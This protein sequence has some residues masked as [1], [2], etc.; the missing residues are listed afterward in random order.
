M[1]TQVPYGPI[2]R[3][4]WLKA[5]NEICGRNTADGF[6]SHFSIIDRCVKAALPEERLL[7]H[8]KFIH[9]MLTRDKSPTQAGYYRDQ[10]DTYHV[11]PKCPH[12]TDVADMV[13]GWM[14]YSKELLRHSSFKTE[15]E[16]YKRI[17]MLHYDF[18]TI[19]P[20]PNDNDRVGRLLILNQCVYADV[21]PIIISAKSYP[22][23]VNE[24]GMATSHYYKKMN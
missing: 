20:F 19:C 8:P 22:N 6:H 2:W 4:A 7:L 14:A 15:S 3:Q 17:L 18:C 23:Y 16:A 9:D 11:P 10:S 12:W 24:I 1:T 5:N 21:D 13:S